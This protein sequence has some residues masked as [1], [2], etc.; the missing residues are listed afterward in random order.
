MDNVVLRKSIIGGL[1]L[2]LVECY[3]VEWMLN[4]KYGMWDFYNYFFV[5]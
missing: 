5:L 2:N 1:F 3:M 4:V